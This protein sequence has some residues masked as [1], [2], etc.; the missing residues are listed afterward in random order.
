LSN[1]ARVRAWVR[2]VDEAGVQ[3]VT[4][5]WL[6][7]LSGHGRLYL[8]SGVTGFTQALTVTRAVNGV[9]RSHSVGESVDLW[10]RPA[11]AR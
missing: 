7:G 11:L 1:T 8:L 10:Y 6:T 3:S 2:E 5:P 4:L 9:S